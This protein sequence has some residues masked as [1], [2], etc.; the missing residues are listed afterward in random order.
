MR[1]FIPPLSWRCCA[2]FEAQ[3]CRVFRVTVV[4]LHMYNDH[5]WY[6]QAAYSVYTNGPNAQF[7][8]KGVGSLMLVV[9]H[10]VKP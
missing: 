10:C 1:R 9:R 7:W 6:G 4:R 2:Q 5:Q 3:F 8:A